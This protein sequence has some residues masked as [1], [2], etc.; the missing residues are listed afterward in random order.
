MVETNCLAKLIQAKRE[1][2]TPSLLVFSETWSAMG[3]AFNLRQVI[4]LRA[5]LRY[6]L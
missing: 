2:S 3:L 1:G 4:D 5:N 6:N